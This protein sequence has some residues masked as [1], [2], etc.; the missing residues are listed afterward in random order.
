MGLGGNLFFGLT[1]LTMAIVGTTVK[2]P[3]R[4]AWIAMVVMLL[5]TALG[6]QTPLFGLLYRVVPGFNLFR[7]PGAFAFQ[8]VPFV[9]MLSAFGMDALI[10]STAR[11]KPATA[12]LLIVGFALTLLGAVL[13]GG[14]SLIF[15]GLRH[16][17]VQVFARYSTFGV[18][19]PNNPAFQAKAE[20]FASTQCLISACICLVLSALL[21][22]LLKRRHVAYVLAVFG[23]AE[24]FGFARF[25]L[26][27]FDLA[28]TVPVQLRHFVTTHPGDYQY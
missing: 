22:A 8:V 7:R 17:L 28:A 19:Q 10:R 2:S 15:D 3:H 21:L 20:L 16:D 1:G 11:A 23:I 6:A 14:G 24:A 5:C 12:A 25:T 13:H 9:A 27:T 4:G 18:S 26:T